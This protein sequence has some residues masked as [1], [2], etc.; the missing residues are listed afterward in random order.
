MLDLKDVIWIKLDLRLSGINQQNTSI[1]AGAMTSESD[2]G[3]ES[4]DEY[5]S[6]TA[7]TKSLV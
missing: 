2:T 1:D 5:I 7:N 6:S 4:E 3:E